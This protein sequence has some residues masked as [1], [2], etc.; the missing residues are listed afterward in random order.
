MGKYSDKADI[1]ITPDGEVLALIKGNII[2]FANA[3]DF[4]SML[5]HLQDKILS[6]LTKVSPIDDQ[7]AETIA[8]DAIRKIDEE[9]LENFPPRYDP[10]GWCGTSALEEAN[11]QLEEQELH[12][13]LLDAAISFFSDQEWEYSQKEKDLLTLQVLTENNGPLNCIFRVSET[14]KQAY[15]YSYIFP[16]VPEGKRATLAEYLTRANYNL[17]VGNFEM[18]FADGE[19]RY[20]TSIDVNG[21]ILTTTMVK[22]LVLINIST[23]ERYIPGIMKAIYSDSD[24]ETLI[25]EIEAN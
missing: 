24:P 13:Y 9:F 4:E 23:A 7:M 12:S 5:K 21:G 16:S 20:K 1:A 6:H 2:P 15:F 10:I 3:E 17:K 22:H 8:E 18:D 11:R 25:T 14:L 19:I